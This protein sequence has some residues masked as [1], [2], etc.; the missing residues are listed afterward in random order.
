MN[1]FLSLRL[2]ISSNRIDEIQ[3]AIT[4]NACQQYCLKETV[5]PDSLFENMFTTTAIDNTDH[6]E[7]SSTISG[8]FNGTSI[9]AFQHYGNLIEEENITYN[10]LKL[11]TKK[12]KIL[13][14]HYTIMILALLVELKVI[15]DFYN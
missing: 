13:S 5:C 7:T 15:P 6:N 10:F 8:P 12:K 9:L 2:C 3:S 4:R 1:K 14:Y 11:I